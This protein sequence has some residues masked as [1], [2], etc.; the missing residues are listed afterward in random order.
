MRY[1]QVQN[2]DGSY[3]LIPATEWQAPATQNIFVQSDVEPFRSVVDGSV[4]T[5]QRAL[6]EH[7]LRNNVVHESEYGSQKDRERFWARK[8]AERADVY[9]GTATTAYGKDIARKRKQAIAEALRRHEK[10]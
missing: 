7:N 5:S 4:V 6:R 2:P 9:Q 1:V 10:H 8:A 3:E